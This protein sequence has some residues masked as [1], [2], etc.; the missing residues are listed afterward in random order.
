MDR[1]VEE[2]RVETHIVMADFRPQNKDQYKIY[3]L[4]DTAET[5]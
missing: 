1:V 5:T 2:Q 4:E 3:M